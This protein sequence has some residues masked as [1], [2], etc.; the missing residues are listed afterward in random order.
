ML[1]DWRE[2]LRMSKENFMKLCDKVKP[3]LQKQSTIMRSAIDVE[4]QVAVT[5]YYVLDEER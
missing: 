5:L 1:D 4:K 2:N 3:F